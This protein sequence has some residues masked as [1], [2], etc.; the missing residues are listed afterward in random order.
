MKGGHIET[1]NVDVRPLRRE[2]FEA[3]VKIDEQ[4]FRR[5]RPEYYGENS[6][7]SWMTKIAWCCR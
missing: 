3:V 2:D 6:I 5:A 7:G 4:V 1:A